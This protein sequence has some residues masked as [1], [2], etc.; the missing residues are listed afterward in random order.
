[1]RI[2]K[3]YAVAYKR[4]ENDNSVFWK[5]NAIC[6]FGQDSYTVERFKE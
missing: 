4:F 3:R 6:I 2:Q 5:G 1:M